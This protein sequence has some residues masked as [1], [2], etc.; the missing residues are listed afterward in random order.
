MWRTCGA[1]FIS[2]A[3]WDWITTAGTRF[4]ANGSDWAVVIAAVTT[5]LWFYSTKLFIANPKTIPWLMAGAVV[6]TWVGLRIP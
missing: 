5:G 1:A 2:F 6:G 4:I 3:T